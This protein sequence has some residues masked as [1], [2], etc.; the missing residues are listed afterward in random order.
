MP[1]AG[2]QRKNKLSWEILQKHVEIHY[3]CD[4]WYEA[5]LLQVVKCDH[6]RN[7]D[8][9]QVKPEKHKVLR[10]LEEH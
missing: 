7:Y 1:F 2:V 10:Y 9:F 4:N 3:S 5:L 6:N 8:Y